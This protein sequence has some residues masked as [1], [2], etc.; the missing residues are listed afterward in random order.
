MTEES[1]KTQEPR[2]VMVE[3][4]QYSSGDEII[5]IANSVWTHSGTLRSASALSTSTPSTSRRVTSCVRVVAT[6][7]TVI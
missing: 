6:L 3:A 5:L 1:D 7:S 2:I 4:S